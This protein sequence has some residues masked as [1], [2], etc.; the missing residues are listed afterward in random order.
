MQVNVDA[1]SGCFTVRDKHS[2]AETPEVQVCPTSQIGVTG[3]IGFTVSAPDMK[4]VYG[5]GEEF[6]TPGKIDGDWVGKVRDSGTDGNPNNLGKEFGNNMTGYNG[7][8]VGNAQF[9][10]LY[11]LGPNKQNLALFFD[12][13]FK[14]RWDFT[15]QPWKVESTGGD[16]QGYVITG[17]DLAHLRSAYMNLTGL[18]PVPPKKAFGLWISEY[19]FD[20]WAELEGKL[21]SLKNAEFPVDGF[22][23]DLQWFGGIKSG[24][25]D[26]AMGG[27]TWDLK[28]F[29]NP[30]EKIA[31]LK[32]QGIGLI[33]IEESYISRGR[34]EFDALAKKGFLAMDGEGPG[35]KPTY[36]DY[37]PWWGKGGMIDWINEAAGQYWHDERRQPL[38][39]MG[40]VGHWTDLGEPEL[41]SAKSIYA[42]PLKHAEIH[43]IYNLKWSQSICEGYARHHVSQR[44]WILTRSGTSGSQRYGVSM[45]SGDIGSNLTS[46][47]SHINVQ[48]HMSL[49]GVD[50]FGSD[51]GG[52]HREAVQGDV[53]EMYTQWFANGSLLDIPV[54]V[55]TENLSNKKETAPDRIGDKA[56]N[57]FNI[58]QRYELI[59]YYYSLAHRAHREGLPV[60]APL[61]F[62]FQDDIHVRELG[63]HKMIGPNLLTA[64]ISAHGQRS[65]DVYLPRGK[66][67]DFHSGAEY[68]SDGMW[69]KNVSA[70]NSQGIFTLPL[71]ARAG[72]IIPEV[73]FVLV[74]PSPNASSFSLY[75]D[76]GSTVAYLSGHVART[77][78]EQA[79]QEGVT[80]I[81]MHASAGDFTPPAKTQQFNIVTNDVPKDVL[82]N[83]QGVPQLA[84]EQWD[85]SPQGWRF[86]KSKAAG[87]IQ[88][89][90]M[91]DPKQDLVLELR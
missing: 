22:V 51:I 57:L 48:M 47:T 2:D 44:P 12:N 6:L 30:A 25:D 59:P 91:R 78:I 53:N 8:A 45:W 37:N 76:D 75:E 68:D 29:P 41:L 87:V 36:L 34:P 35:A 28:N 17:P 58:R 23:L 31:E 54:R 5:L 10:I 3:P 15:S 50:Y 39:D 63:D 83:G 84:A 89:K 88:V 82:V 77:F 13:I 26:S 74:Y 81:T 72:A 52:F 14:H 67:F 60:V 4:N 1:K 43:N 38:V 62:Y 46:L 24:A 49:S 40:I 79:M 21:A 64:T 56:S 42:G 7:G 55:H 16:V 86:L 19:G 71:F 32:K 33:T 66:W 85:G 20:N 70:V 73:S 90:A 69:F 65:R 27:L 61:L 11:A 18:P 9:P 80:T